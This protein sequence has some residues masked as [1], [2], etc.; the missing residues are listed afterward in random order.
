MSA[1]FSTVPTSP[2]GGD[3]LAAADEIP[4]MQ[5]IVPNSVR[6]AVPPELSSSS[7]VSPWPSGFLASRCDV[8]PTKV[9]ASS[10][11]PR[12]YSATPA[13]TTAASAAAHLFV[14]CVFAQSDIVL[15]VVGSGRAPEHLEASLLVLHGVTALVLVTIFLRSLCHTPRVGVRG[16]GSEASSSFVVRRQALDYF[17]W[18]VLVPSLHFGLALVSTLRRSLLWTVRQYDAHEAAGFQFVQRAAIL[19][20]LYMFV[21]PI[22]RSV[23]HVVQIIYA[24]VCVLTFVTLSIILL[25]QA[26][27]HSK[28]GIT[29][30]AT[31]MLEGVLLLI[32]V[33]VV[34]CTKP[35]R[36]CA[37]LGKANGDVDGS[38]RVGA[39]VRG[40]E[41]FT[42]SRT[43]P[44]DRRPS[45]ESLTE[46]ALLDALGPLM[47]GSL[48][49]RYR[50]P[51]D[52]AE[53]S[54]ALL[55]LLARL[56]Q[57][58]RR[59]EASEG[60]NLRLRKCFHDAFSH[61]CAE[62]ESSTCAKSAP[63]GEPV[64]LSAHARSSAPSPNHKPRRTSR[65]SGFDTDNTST[66]CPTMTFDNGL[67]NDRL[68]FE[69][70]AFLNY[71]E[72]PVRSHHIMSDEARAL[73]QNTAGRWDTDVLDLVGRTQGSILV[74]IASQVMKK[75]CEALHIQAE[76]LNT[77]VGNVEVRYRAA[78]PYHNSTHAADVLNSMTYLVNLG[79]SMMGK[80]NAVEVFAGQIA[81]AAHDV[82]HD[83]FSNRF[84]VAAGTSLATLYN[85]Q[86]VL[87]NMHCA[88][89]FAVLKTESK[90]MLQT[91][92][93][94]ARNT[95]RS[96]VIQSILVTDLAKS[97]EATARHKKTLLV[98][99]GSDGNH[100]APNQEQRHEL[101]RLAMRCSDI[102][103]AAKP[104][105]SHV[106]WTLR[107]TTEFF[108][109]GDAEHRLGLPI[110]PS[111]C[112]RTTR[113]PESQRGFFD[114]IVT[115]LL[116][117][118]DQCFKEKVFFEEVLCGK[119]RNRD[120]WRA[121]DESGVDLDNTAP[122]ENCKFLRRAAKRHHS[123]GSRSFSIFPNGFRE[124]DTMI[125]PTDSRH[126]SELRWHTAPG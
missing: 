6:T 76:T 52:T 123:A 49:N 13:F 51:L 109:Q 55:R 61:I 35:G 26:A 78:N 64:G 92:D 80:L 46:D 74:R 54:E 90:D 87:E 62:I 125:L 84:Q 99:E 43:S 96:I 113:I 22:R 12:R 77:F 33:C 48:G 45:H 101:L 32:V 14:A 71:R 119:E 70:V 29:A 53:A 60:V 117:T 21:C 104:L 82:G 97:A 112:R 116:E 56:V 72:D 11:S 121:V 122:V 5:L 31:S 67:P 28:S 2:R 91:L 8:E 124:L 73:L 75:S 25:T 126:A 59:L 94:K 85:D 93:L 66:E 27:P 108:S 34:T 23:V 15:T 120:F 111:H 115:P 37:V 63:V 57:T 4:E 7:T 38:D 1:A 114:F 103:H 95:V 69:L 79:G 41:C 100:P 20:L 3:R 118:A 89:T 19:Q 36:G 58:K 18:G 68:S 106:E 47:I 88:I 81:A 24:T 102:G 86:S 83:G 98:A 17:L 10:A 50:Q 107:I 65:G 44:K 105:D 110:S 42:D 39:S 40:S 9:M 30:V 16:V